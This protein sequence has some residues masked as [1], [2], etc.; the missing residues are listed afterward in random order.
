MQVSTKVDSYGA[1]VRKKGDGVAYN[2]LQVS[3]HNLKNMCTAHILRRKY[4]E[5]LKN[6]CSAHIF[7]QG[8]GFQFY[9]ELCHF[10]I[11]F[12]ERGAGVPARL[13]KIP[14]LWNFITNGTSK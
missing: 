10:G 7:K 14:V 5:K 12:R 1:S 8:K 6:M 4:Y 3:M 11:L 9:S 13:A 2:R